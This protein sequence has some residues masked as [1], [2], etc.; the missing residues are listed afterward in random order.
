[1][2]PITPAVSIVLSQ[3]VLDKPPELGVGGLNCR[4]KP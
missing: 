1:M 2:E 3:I 4:N